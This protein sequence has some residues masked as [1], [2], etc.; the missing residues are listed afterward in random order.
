[1][2]TDLSDL[3]RPPGHHRR[4]RR[5]ADDRAAARA[6]PVVLMSRNPR[7]A[8]KPPACGRRAASPHRSARMTRLPCISPI[9]SRPAPASAT[10]R[11]H[12]GSS[13]RRLPPPSSIWPNSASPSTVAPTAV[14]ASGSEAAHGRN[15]IVHA[16]GDGTGREIMRALIA[17]VRPTPSITRAGR[18]RGAPAARRGQC[19]QG[20]ARRPVSADALTIATNRVVIATGG[21][22]GLFADSTNPGRMLRPGARARG[23]CRRNTCRT[24]NS[25]SSIRPPR[26]AVAADAAAHRSDPR[27]RRGAD[28]RDRRALHGRS[29]GAELAPRDIVARAV[30]RHRAA[31]IAPSSMRARIPAR[32]SRSAIR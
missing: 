8:R 2:S 19:G 31:D 12:P 22:G 29:A 3:E 32:I 30:W 5:G 18:R 27:R 6:E 14:G 28:R 17:A 10:R 21:I 4:R 13:M 25:S 26:R 16:T 7:S 1:M 11:Q 24:S 20:R 23:T 9:R 15:R